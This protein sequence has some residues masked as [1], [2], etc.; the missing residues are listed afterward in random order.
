LYRIQ[1]HIEVYYYGM[2]LLELHR[3]TGVVLPVTCAG[4]AFFL[5]SFILTTENFI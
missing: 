3:A 1:C 2:T 5:I 4:E